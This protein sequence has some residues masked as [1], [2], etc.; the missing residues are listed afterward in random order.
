MPSAAEETKDLRAWAEQHRFSGFLPAVIDELGVEGVEDLQ[1]VTE[2]D[3]RLIGLK[4]IQTR[5]LLLL[6]APPPAAT[7]LT[8]TGLPGSAGGDGNF[9]V[10]STR[11]ACTA[12][13]IASASCGGD[14]RDDQWVP[15]EEE[16]D[17]SPPVKRRKTTRRS[18]D[19][20]TTRDATT[21][22][23]GARLSQ[24]GR[25]AKGMRQMSSPEATSKGIAR[26]SPAVGTRGTCKCAELLA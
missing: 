2:A 25:Y 13:V 17:P 26:A 22:L 4:P 23:S 21:S 1:L 20:V 5:R 16:R 6:V 8:A 11:V 7:P 14:E 15:T 10:T 9:A 18:G 12:D 3:L 19:Q 24:P